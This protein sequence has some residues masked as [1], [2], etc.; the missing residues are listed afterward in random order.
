M[1]IGNIFVRRL[2]IFMLKNISQNGL[3][4]SVYMLYLSVGFD[5]GPRNFSKGGTTFEAK[6]FLFLD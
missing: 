3:T 5:H 2:F 4:R 1:Y 6:P